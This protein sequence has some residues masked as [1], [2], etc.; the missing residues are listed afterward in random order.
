MYHGGTNERQPS[1]LHMERKEGGREKWQ[2][3]TVYKEGMDQWLL[4]E[5]SDPA[6]KGS[7]KDLEVA[8]AG[9]VNCHFPLPPFF[10]Y[11]V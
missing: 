6:A 2:W 8:G 7:A 1:E 3:Q 10:P 9:S 11:H 4:A 5:T